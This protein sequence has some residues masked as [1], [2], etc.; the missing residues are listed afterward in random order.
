M[1]PPSSRSDRDVVFCFAA[2]LD[3]VNKELVS[4]N[5]IKSPSTLNA[6]ISDTRARLLHIVSHIAM[7]NCVFNSWINSS[8]LKVEIGSNADA[9]LIQQKDFGFYRNR[10][11]NQPKNAAAWPPDQLPKHFRVDGFF[12][13]V[14]H[15]RGRAQ[16]PST[17]GFRLKDFFINALNTASLKRRSR[18]CLLGMGWA[19]G[20]TIPSDG[21]ASSPQSVPLWHKNILVHVDWFHPEYGKAK[22]T[23]S[24][25]RLKTAA[26]KSR[27]YQQTRRVR[28]KKLPS[29]F[30]FR[31]K[32]MLFYPF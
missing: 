31:D 20:N 1:R 32:N 19:F 5:S 10:A 13:F 18:K 4:P 25:M 3:F 6:R 14:A 16:C 29:P 22:S 2:Y 24:F 8:N 15:K 21:A 26:I 28:L 30:F 27:F 9:A 23:K 12:Y 7:V 11:R 17:P